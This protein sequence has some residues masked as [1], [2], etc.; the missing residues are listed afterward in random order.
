MADE[1]TAKY[2]V[3]VSYRWVDPD[4]TWVREQLAPS[5]MAAGLS[6]CLDVNDFTPGRDIFDEMTRAGVES[7]RGVCVISPDYLEGN[8]FATY[9][10]NMLQRLD[11]SGTESRLIPLLFRGTGLPERLS[12]LVPVDWTNPGG[13]VREW[14]KL[15]RVLGAKNLNATDPESLKSYPGL[16]YREI[17][18]VKILEKYKGAG[19]HIFPQVLPEVLP[20]ARR[21]CGV[22]A[23]EKILGLVTLSLPINPFKDY[24]LFGRDGIYFR[25]SPR[26]LQPAAIPYGEFPDRTY[27]RGGDIYERLTRKV[28]FGNGQFV[29]TPD[30]PPDTLAEMLNAIKEAVINNSLDDDP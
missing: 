26:S 29:I 2:D 4:K 19:L 23:D 17:K 24:L 3:F 1:G 11:P 14:K 7:L 28:T 27:A 21:V 12:G 6:V 10:R 16:S 15:L 20:S 9:E 22:P 25:S 18:I 8:R 5:L 30:V 13:R